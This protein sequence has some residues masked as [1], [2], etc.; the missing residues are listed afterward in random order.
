MDGHSYL[1][2]EVSKQMIELEEKLQSR[3]FL[4][5]SRDREAWIRDVG[6]AADAVALRQEYFQCNHIVH[7]TF[8]LYIC[9][10]LLL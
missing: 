9:F 5:G 3:H 4:A 10:S 7:L 1:L 8:L 6:Q 2:R